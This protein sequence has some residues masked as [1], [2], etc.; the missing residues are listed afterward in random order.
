MV[1]A[2]VG[3]QLVASV[4]VVFATFLPWVY[5]GQRSIDAYDAAALAARL[6][7]LSDPWQARPMAL[8]PFV[9][10]VTVALRVLRRPSLAAVGGGL[11]GL[12]VAAAG[13]GAWTMLASGIR[14]PGPILAVVASIPLLVAA[15]AELRWRGWAGLHASSGC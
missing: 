12:Y 14:G 13:L 9:L 8:V 15:M 5:S 1:V 11:V 2:S 3:V 10:A 7:V 4:F 6:D